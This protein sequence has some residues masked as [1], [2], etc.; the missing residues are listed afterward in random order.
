MAFKEKVGVFETYDRAR[1]GPKVDEK[2]W[3][4][5]ATHGWS[6]CRD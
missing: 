3:D 5:E 6:V 2:E 4:R 1:T